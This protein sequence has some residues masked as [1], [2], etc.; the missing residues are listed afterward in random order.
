MF[1]Y[2]NEQEL[3]SECAKVPEVDYIINCKNANPETS[4]EVP[5]FEPV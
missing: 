2:P 5:M 3:E 1:L 4:L